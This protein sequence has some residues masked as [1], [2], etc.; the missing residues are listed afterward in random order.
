VIR[1]VY[2]SKVSTCVYAFLLNKSI[3]SYRTVLQ[4]VIIK[5]IQV[6]R[7]SKPKYVI[8]DFEIAAMNATN[9]VFGDSVQF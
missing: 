6:N 4:Q 8:M 3:K 9:G 5:C 1:G 2:E 7:H